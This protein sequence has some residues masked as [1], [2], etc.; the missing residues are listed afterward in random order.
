[1]HEDLLTLACSYL[2]PNNWLFTDRV[3]GEWQAFDQILSR[4]LRKMREEAMNIQTKIL[5][6]DANLDNRVK[7]FIADWKKNRPVQGDLAYKT[8]EN[9]LSVFDKNLTRLEVRQKG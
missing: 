7:E 1:M 3:Q 8:V 5:A 9:Q 2:F 6:E 4:Q